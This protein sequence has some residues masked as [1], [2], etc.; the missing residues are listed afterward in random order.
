[1]GGRGGGGSKFRLKDQGTAV[2]KCASGVAI[3]EIR[4]GR[5]HPLTA[6]SC[7]RPYH[8]AF[9]PSNPHAC[10]GYTANL[11]SPNTPSPQPTAQSYRASASSWAWSLPM[12]PTLSIPQS[13]RLKAHALLPVQPPH[14]PLTARSCGTSAPTAAWPACGRRPNPW[15]TGASPPH[16]A[17]PGWP[18]WPAAA[19]PS[20]QTAPAVIR[21]W[22]GACRG[23]SAM[24]RGAGHEVCSLQPPFR[25]L[26]TLQL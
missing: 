19:L 12:P 8:P 2:I 4:S 15:R 9:S 22:E 13:R 5:S 6:Q 18:G 21:K 3:Y 1:V 26:K 17:W 7:I 23:T 24:R 10:A 14:P 20:A 11:A 16:S 25:L